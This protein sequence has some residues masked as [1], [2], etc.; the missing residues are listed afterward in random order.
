[1][2]RTPGA[3]EFCTDTRRYSAEQIDELILENKCTKKRR[4]EKNPDLALR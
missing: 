2:H 4:W 3:Q 1:M